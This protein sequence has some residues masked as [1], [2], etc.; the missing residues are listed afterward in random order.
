MV[1]DAS[2]AA[3]AAAVDPIACLVSGGPGV[4]RS[5]ALAYIEVSRRTVI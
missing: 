5:P 1:S 3:A 2:A 4:K